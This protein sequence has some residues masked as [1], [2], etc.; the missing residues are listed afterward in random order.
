M[1]TQEQ[2]LLQDLFQRL[3]QTHGAAKDPQAD[4]E[5][6]AGLAAV[7]DAP[8]WLA[9]RTLVLEQALQQ[10]QQQIAQLQQQAAAAQGGNNFLSG[11]LG[12]DFGRRPEAQ[13]FQPAFQ[14]QGRPAEMPTQTAQT[15]APSWRERWFGGAPSTR[16]AAPAAPMSAPMSGGGS[17]FLGNAAATAAGMAGGMFL[18]NGL[19]NLL[20]GHHGSNSLLSGNNPGQPEVQENVTQN[21]FGGGDEGREQMARDAGIDDIGASDNSFDDGGGFFDDDNFA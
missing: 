12:T 15:S 16:M 7:P 14:N 6:R 10:A 20:G 8:Y 18:F 19:E 13:E 11:G 3:Q 2:Q 4:A 1:N 21:Y 17:S 9:Q 5:I